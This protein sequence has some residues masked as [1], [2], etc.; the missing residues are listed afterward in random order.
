MKLKLDS[1]LSHC[2]DDEELVLMPSLKWPSTS[3]LKC[4]TLSCENDT[5]A[6][7]RVAKC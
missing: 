6:V 1:D 7:C 4:K 5:V 2:K 3:E